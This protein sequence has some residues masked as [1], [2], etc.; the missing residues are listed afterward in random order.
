MVQSA[1]SSASSTNTFS[2][3]SISVPSRSSAVVATKKKFAL[4]KLQSKVRTVMETIREN[5]S[6]LNVD[7]AVA[8]RNKSSSDSKKKYKKSIGHKEVDDPSTNTNEKNG[9]SENDLESGV[10]RRR[11]SRKKK[12][13]T[14]GVCVFSI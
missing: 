10:R 14:K 12:K 8:I 4:F 3:A 9:N 11:S 2:E 1:V 5:V 6:D 7:H 13:K